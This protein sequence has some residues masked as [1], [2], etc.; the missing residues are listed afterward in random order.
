V[1]SQA[2]A[3]FA[4]LPWDIDDL[5]FTDAKR[6]WLRSIS[7]PEAAGI[8]ALVRSEVAAEPEAAAEIRRLKDLLHF[9]ALA[10]AEER[11]WR[12]LTAEQCA[13][14]VESCGRRGTSKT[15]EMARGV[16]DNVLLIR[17]GTSIRE[18]DP[19]NRGVSASTTQPLIAT[20]LNGFY[21]EAIEAA[22][23]RLSLPG[24]AAAEFDL[25]PRPPKRFGIF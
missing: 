1:E 2:W 5:R 6:S 7:D 13:A 9:R 15:E 21:P 20:L 23:E 3:Q 14:L 8:L 25:G 11:V 17:A 18:S 4:N 12:S 19:S 22:G 16:I 24:A 10:L